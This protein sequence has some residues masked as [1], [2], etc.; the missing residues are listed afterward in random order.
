[1][2]TARKIRKHRPGVYR[3]TLDVDQFAQ[4]IRCRYYSSI[5]GLQD[6]VKDDPKGKWWRVEVRCAIVGTLY[7][8]A[9]IWRTLADCA[10]AVG[11]K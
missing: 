7:R 3:M 11:G 8:H 9:G 6:K 10:A 5:G 1:M 2:S 4:F